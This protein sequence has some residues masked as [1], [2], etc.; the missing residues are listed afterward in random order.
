M[1][2]TNAITYQVK[3]LIKLAYVL[4]AIGISLSTVILGKSTTANG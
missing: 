4:I 2:A 3:P 1:L